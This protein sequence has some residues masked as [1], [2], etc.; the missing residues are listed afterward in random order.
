MSHYDSIST[1]SLSYLAPLKNLWSL[2]MK[3]GGIRSFAGIDGK[4]SIKYLELWQIREL[5][6]VEILIDLPGLQNLFLQALPHITYQ[7]PP[8]RKMAA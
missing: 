2:A 5:R 3:L 8:P 4:A 6:D 7:H 1:P